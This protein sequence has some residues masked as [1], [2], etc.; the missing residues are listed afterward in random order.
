VKTERAIAIINGALS[1]VG[2]D[3]K[4]TT[5]GW[6]FGGGWALQAALL[7]GKQGAGCVMYYGMPEKDVDKLKALNSDV[8][9]VFATKDQWINKEVVTAFEK[10]MRAANKKLT[11][12]NYDA[13]HAF[14]NPSNPHYNKE[15]SE[16]A[17]KLALAFIKEHL[18]S[19][20]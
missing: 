17:H 10:D 13:D 9:G 3:A 7:A 11:V 8:L 4:V 1:Y 20:K 12:V 16:A 5:I 2:N 15:Y 14:A 19:N 18:K 6:C